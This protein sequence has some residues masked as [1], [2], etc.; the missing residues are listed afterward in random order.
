VTVGQYADSW[1]KTHDARERTLYHYGVIV[2]RWITPHL[3]TTAMTSVTTK[4]V[5][6][7]LALFPKDHPAA[8]ANA[9]R[10]LAQLFRAAEED[11][12]VTTSPVKVKGAGQYQR[13]REGHALTAKEVHDLAGKVPEA[14]RLAILLSA[15]CAL[16]PGEVLGLRRRDVDTR[17]DTLHVRETASAVHGGSTRVGPTKTVAGIRDVAYP[18]QLH[19]DVDAHLKEHT[20]KGPAGHLFPSPRDPEQPLSYGGYLYMFREAV[21]AVGLDDVKPHDLRHTGLT[22]AAQSGATTRELMARAGHT[23]SQVAMRYQH[24]ARERDRAIADALGTDL[25]AAAKHN[26]ER[27]QDDADH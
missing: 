17:T 8:R 13:K 18:A 19:A 27:D 12:I 10:V 14:R 20:V 25:E 2:D 16:R 21:K 11:G 4:M 9:Y 26:D 3:G 15:Y 5:R 7:W 24:S 6:D 1:L 23:T 22:L